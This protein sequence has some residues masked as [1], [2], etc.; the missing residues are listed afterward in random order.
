MSKSK[1]AVIAISL[2]A[3]VSS[4]YIYFAHKNPKVDNTPIESAIKAKLTRFE[5]YRYR[6][7]QLVARA[8]GNDAIL[9]PRGRFVCDGRTRFVQ[10]SGGQRQE[11]ES[12]KAEVMFQSEN[13]FGEG[14]G[15]IDT[16]L[17]S[18]NVDYIRG[19]SRFQTDWIKF[20]EKTKEATTDRP[21]RF[22]SDGQFI[23][24][25]GGMIYNVK[26]EAIKMK[27]GV[28]GSVRTDVVTTSGGGARKK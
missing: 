19:N 26:S 4:L 21:V 13:L 10:I 1:L 18:G 16:I 14:A 9:F 17:F 25:E 7:D 24:A 23:A 22:E 15:L 8:T 12:D 2:M 20:S 27:G 11:I 5:L 3:T 6:G 28:F